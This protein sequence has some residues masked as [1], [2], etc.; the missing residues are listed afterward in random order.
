M[1]TN[2]N[3]STIYYT[4]NDNLFTFLDF[5]M[6]EEDYI[7]KANK[8]RSL[9]EDDP[10]RMSTGKHR[11]FGYNCKRSRESYYKIIR[12][13]L[14]SKVGQHWDKAWADIC[15]GHD[16]IDKDELRKATRDAI[17]YY[18]EQNVMIKDGE[19]KKGNGKNIYCPFYIHPLTKILCATPNRPKYRRPKP[20]RPIEYDGQKFFKEDDIWYQ[21]ILKDIEKLDPVKY[22]KYY[23]I[24]WDVYDVF[25]KAFM[26]EQEC[27]RFYGSSI[28][29]VAKKQIGKRLIKKIEN[30][31]SAKGK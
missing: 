23:N 12:K 11:Q 19:M 28:Y 31:L 30:H 22:P 26:T 27:I 1:G 6:S 15:K 3:F 24:R 2:S 25:K 29:C 7:Y 8:N 17:D 14:K 9:S 21:I 18:V 10:T 16:D 5:V 13:L 20:V 4:K